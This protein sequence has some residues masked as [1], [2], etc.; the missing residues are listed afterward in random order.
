MVENDPSCQTVL[1]RHFP[2]TEVFGDI[3]EVEPRFLA[4]VDLICGGF[5]CQDVSV[6]GNRAGLGG[7]RS[8]LWWE[9]YRILEW[10]RPE[11]VLIENVAGLLSSNGGRDM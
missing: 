5:P 8:G 7:T 2:E 10:Q 6:A 1:T 4:P 9:F 3:T 11:Y